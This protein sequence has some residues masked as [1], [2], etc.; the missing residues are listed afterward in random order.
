MGV[1]PPF[2]QK[3]SGRWQERKLLSQKESCHLYVAC[4]LLHSGSQ[5]TWM[6]EILQENLLAWPLLSNWRGGSGG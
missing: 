4:F 3:P 1:P 2:L 5:A 6:Q